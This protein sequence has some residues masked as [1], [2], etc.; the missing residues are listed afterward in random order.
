MGRIEMQEIAVGQR[1]R[2]RSIIDAGFMVGGGTAFWEALVTC[3][4]TL[5]QSPPAQQQWIVALT[6]G[7]DRHSRQH[8]LESARAAVQAAE[9]KANLIVIGI[10]LC[11]GLKPDMERLCT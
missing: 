10:Q 2:L 5:K 8:T 4:D 1:S 9:G 11:H 6:D 3:V 7:E